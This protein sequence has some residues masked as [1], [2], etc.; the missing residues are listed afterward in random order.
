MGGLQ[1][2]L[3]E[4]TQRVETISQE[5]KGNKGGVLGFLPFGR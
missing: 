1:K 5:R 4:T 3:K 2:L